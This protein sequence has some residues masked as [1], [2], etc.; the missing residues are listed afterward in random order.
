[1]RFCVIHRSFGKY[2]SVT[3]C[4]TAGFLI[5]FLNNFLKKY[6]ASVAVKHVWEYQL[7]T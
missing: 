3:F 4:L 7:V 1:M 2:V 5:V 6:D